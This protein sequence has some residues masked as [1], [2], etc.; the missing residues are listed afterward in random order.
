MTDIEIEKLSDSI[1]R[2]LQPRINEIVE[3]A[4]EEYR[5]D[6]IRSIAGILDDAA[7]RVR[8]TLKDD[9]E[10]NPGS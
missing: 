8:E 7:H 9:Q 1:A 2:K 4:I 3:D 5:R 6:E 10:V